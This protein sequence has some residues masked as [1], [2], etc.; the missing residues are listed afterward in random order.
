[1]PDIVLAL[2]TATSATVVGL[3]GPGILEPI[4]R[5]DEPEGGGRSRHAEALLP[6]A[7]DALRAADLDFRDVERVVVGTGPGLRSGLEVGIAAGRA[8]ALAAGAEIVGVSTLRALAE[9]A[10]AA[11]GPQSVVA[12]VLVARR[13]RVHMAAWRAGHVVLTPRRVSPDRAAELAREGGAWK[14]RVWLAVGDGAMLFRS[15]LE[16]AGV[17]V[18]ADRSVLHRV[19]AR[20]LCRIGAE[21]DAVDRAAVVPAVEA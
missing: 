6:L 18:P 19:D 20:V 9:P 5:R 13:D 14:R 10:E 11:V 12:P 1:M 3:S 8:M 15:A 16:A 7:R 17:S 21:A 4:E 2:D